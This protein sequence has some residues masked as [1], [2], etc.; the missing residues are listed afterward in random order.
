[1]KPIIEPDNYCTIELQQQATV[2]TH[3]RSDNQRRRKT[4]IFSFKHF[5]VKK[6]IPQLFCNMQY[7]HLLE[8]SISMVGLHRKVQ[9][10]TLITQLVMQLSTLIIKQ[11]YPICEIVISGK[12]AEC[13][14]RRVRY[15]SLWYKYRIG[16]EIIMLFILLGYFGASN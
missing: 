2:R 15:D 11:A 13:V 1:M 3:N 6:I 16:V 4:F 9:H 10:C 5:I 12:L 7:H 8:I 14:F